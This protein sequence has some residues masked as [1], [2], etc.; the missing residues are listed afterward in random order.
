MT[1][2]LTVIEIVAIHDRMIRDYGG[3]DGIRDAGAIEAACFRP[4]SGYYN[5]IIEEAAALM[6]SLAMNHPF[7]DGNKRVAFAATDVFLRIN[8]YAI[9]ADSSLLF[10]EIIT[11]LEEQRFEKHYLE[12]LLR[13][14]TRKV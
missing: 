12:A 2:Y 11:L 6:E 10:K 8:G 9:Y 4:Q 1:L 3:A 7:I 5:D 13:Q 14:Y